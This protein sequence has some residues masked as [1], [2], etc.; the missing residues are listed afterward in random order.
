[1]LSL[2]TPYPTFVHPTRTS[3]LD[4]T[5]LGI[6]TESAL[7]PKIADLPITN[8]PTFK[9]SV[10]ALDPEGDAHRNGVLVGDQVILSDLI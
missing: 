7:P 8:L 2:C 5:G 3:E 4:R 6:K 9:T 10:T 1:L